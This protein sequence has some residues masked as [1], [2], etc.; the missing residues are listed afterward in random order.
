MKLYKAIYEIVLVLRMD[1][2]CG[3][4]KQGICNGNFFLQAEDEAAAETAALEVIEK[5]FLHD[6]ISALEI[7][8]VNIDFPEA[9]VECE[10]CSFQN[11]GCCILDFP[12][13]EFEE[14]YAAQDMKEGD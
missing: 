13:F 12:C 11:E 3:I 8:E 7:E 10:K 2:P 14:D 9:S 6:S 4:M 1:E 5:N